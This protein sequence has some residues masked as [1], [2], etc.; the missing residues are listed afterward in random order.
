MMVAIEQ[1]GCKHYV[2]FTKPTR[3]RGMTANTENW[4]IDQVLGELGEQ[5]RETGV[6][7]AQVF[8]GS[9]GDVARTAVELVNLAAGAAGA[10]TPKMGRVSNLARSF[11]LTA[12]PAVFAALA[13][14]P[15]VKSILPSNIKDIYPRSLGPSGSG[16]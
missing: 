15:R 14:D 7:P 11:A 8:L 4:S 1:H 10:S 2:F 12:A 16:G 13:R 6:V 9:G 5:A 3:S